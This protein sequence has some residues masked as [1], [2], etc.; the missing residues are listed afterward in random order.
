MK[1]GGQAQAVRMPGMAGRGMAAGVF[2]TG[3]FFRL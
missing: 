1:R 3:R 2:V